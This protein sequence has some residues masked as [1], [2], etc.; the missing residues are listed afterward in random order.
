MAE[1]LI[2]QSSHEGQEI[3]DAVDNLGTPQDTSDED[4]AFGR[5]AKL[6]QDVGEA[7]D[8]AA[9][10]GS[11]YARQKQDAADIAAI[12]D[13]GTLN[14]LLTAYLNVSYNGDGTWTANGITDMSYD[15]MLTALTESAGFCL[16]GTSFRYRFSRSKARTILLMK[17][18]QILPLWA[19]SSYVMKSINAPDCFRMFFWSDLEVIVLANS[20][21]TSNSLLVANAEGMFN[22][23][24]TRKIL[25]QK[26]EAAA[27]DLNL[28][29]NANLVKDM[30]L[31]TPNLEEV[32]I[33]GLKVSLS[34]S[35]SPNLS[36][37][38]ILYIIQNSTA[39]S[40]ITITLHPTAYAM[41]IA[42]NDI[43]AALQEKTFVSLA[44]AETTE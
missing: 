29:D 22:S 9:A 23:C 6:R 1:E 3:D 15:D 13:A 32:K 18:Y 20:E 41:A 44:Q 43:Q 16:Y 37:N 31:K 33:K 21:D 8:E 38:S 27:I 11:L 30:F 4:T 10:D 19:Y 24:N 28:I 2:Y 40:A 25:N 34:F 12:K 26:P 36:K 14:D 39:T 42:D 17:K 7:T 5:I 35:D